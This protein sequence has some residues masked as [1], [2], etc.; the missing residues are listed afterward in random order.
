MAWI[1]TEDGFGSVNRICLPHPYDEYNTGE[2]VTVTGWGVM[3]E[4]EGRI[5]NA[6]NVVEIPVVS[7]EECKVAYGQRVGKDHV[8]AG[9]K[10]GG[11]DSCQG[12]SGGPLFRQRGGQRE[13]VGVVSFGYGCAQAGS[14]GVYTKVSHYIDWIKQNL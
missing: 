11:K 13:L 9:L 7:L 4:E 1:F 10:E 2:N 12:D 3:A 8:C 6:L 5:S 14:P